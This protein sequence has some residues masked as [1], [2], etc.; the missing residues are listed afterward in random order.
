M[1]NAPSRSSARR[2]P[3]ATVPRCHLLEAGP[4][5][6]RQEYGII[7]PGPCRSPSWPRCRS[8]FPLALFPCRRPGLEAG[9]R[10]TVCMHIMVTTSPVIALAAVLEIVHHLQHPSPMKQPP[11]PSSAPHLAVVVRRG[12]AAGRQHQ[13]F[14]LSVGLF[15]FECCRHRG[16][17]SP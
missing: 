12:R 4:P 10:Q 2:S 8:L 16:K 17:L 14:L 3:V 6:H 5:G 11:P 13:P 9:H 1:V 15:P 7:H